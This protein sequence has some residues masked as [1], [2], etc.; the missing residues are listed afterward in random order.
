MKAQA[1]AAASAAA[2]QK[3]RRPPKVYISY[4]HD[5][6]EHK[7]R[8]LQLSNSLREDGIDCT[9]DRYELSPTEGW[10][11][12]SET[13]I[14]ESDF[15]LAA[16]TETYHRR[17]L[18]RELSDFDAGSRY[19]GQ[20]II[21]LL[22]TRKTPSEKPTFVPVIF[23]PADAEFI[24]GVLARYTRFN[25][26]SAEDYRRLVLLLTGGQEIERPLVAR[27]IVTETTQSAQAKSP[28]TTT[29]GAP[30]PEESSRAFQLNP[31]RFTQ[32]AWDVILVARRLGDSPR[33]PCSTGRLVAAVMMSGFR[34][35]GG[36][37]TGGWLLNQGNLP[38]EEIAGRLGKT[39]PIFEEFRRSFPAVVNARAPEAATMT[40]PLGRTLD[41]AERLTVESSPGETG[42]PIAVRHLLAAAV[43]R[44]N[45]DPEVEEFLGNFQLAPGEIRAK[46]IEALP[47]WGV[48]DDPEVWRNILD[49]PETT[50][51]ELGL[52]TY[53]A[54]SVA[55][56]DSIGITREVEAMA[57]L[58][59]AWSV[60][61]P[62]S[63]GLFG[64]WG[65][66]KSFFM[67]KMKERV[68][69]IASAARKSGS[70]QK[71][72]GY[73]KN[74]VQV[75]F[76]AWHYVEGNLWASLVEHIFSNLRLE[77]IGEEDLDS[78]QNIRDRLEKLLGNLREKTAEAVQKE[79]QAAISS[80]EAETKKQAAEKL[81]Q[82]LEGEA[83][84][85]RELARKAE[86]AGREAART[87]A[88]K[89]R[90]ADA[91][92]L[93]RE[94][95]AIKDVV[96]EVA[97]S[98][99]IRGQVQRDLEAVGITPERIKTGE[100]LR[101]AL[102]EASDAGIVLGEGIRMVANDKQRWR[103]VLWVVA[104]PIVMAILVWAGA[105]LTSQQDAAWV[106]SIIGAASA[107]ATVIAGVTGF[108]KRYAPRL[109]PFL[110][111]VAR[112]KEKRATLEQ[113]LQKAR[114]ERAKRAAE[115]DLEA[116]TKREEAAE[117]TRLAQKKIDQ[118][119]AARSAAKDK[120]VDADRAALLAQTAREEAEKMR[121]E[122][123]ALVPE[124]RIAAFIQDRAGAKDYRRHLGVP[125]LIRRDFEKLSAMFNTQRMQEDKGL[126]G[127]AAT[128]RNDLAIVNRIILYIDDLDRCPPEKVV[129][130]LRA[131][132]LLLAFPLFVVI[133]AVDARWMKRSLQDRFSLM[134]TPTL[135]GAN[136]KR[137]MS[138]EEK[139]A[140]GPMA[141]PDDYLEK[142]FQ[143]PFWIRPLNKTACQRLVNSLTKEDME[144]E[145]S[146]QENKDPAKDS[147]EKKNADAKEKTAPGDSGV[148]QP[149]PIGDAV[150]LKTE[151][152]AA[153][154]TGP[155]KPKE[156]KPDL[157]M[158]WSK[159][160]PKPRTLQLTKEERDYMVELALVI[161]RSPRSVKRFVNC[162]R[163]L[164]TALDKNDL[165]RVAR[166]GT[167]RTTMLLLGLVS[168]LPDL[169]PSLLADLRAAKKTMRPVAWAQQAA[170]RLDLGQQARWKEFLPAIQRL[171][172]VSKVDTI[173]P[174]LK[175]ADLVDR[176]SFSPVRSAPF[177][178]KD[179]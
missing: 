151:T 179:G 59:S 72:F 38:S 127:F 22:Q 148:T 94:S 99:E 93:E 141:T 173:S 107:A 123:E 149:A 50:P 138:K 116:Q 18:G 106:Q 132:H 71:E 166:D 119:E 96:E 27:K 31:Q 2:S 67:Q 76:N 79:E 7:S 74:I 129:E 158:E 10:R 91:V 32:Y 42:V 105:W 167:F 63:I 29:S 17:F 147:G 177:A 171:S 60:Q 145:S 152:A 39:H 54:D 55:G 101:E 4:S 153:G 165:E 142:I 102:K 104:A 143:V 43:A 6:S 170:K 84:E 137:A 168:G 86:E 175:A 57:S 41:L 95:I 139:L 125:A 135:D 178:A 83:A 3:S 154:E 128:G 82:K 155:K 20:L 56:P 115:L 78:E 21:H 124:R 28:A 80:Q 144:I 162:Y 37:Y 92:A 26:G 64:E 53:A 108:W 157:G 5:S 131:I 97:G 11:R 112:I 85:A 58:V 172:T 114:E 164:K 13:Q 23:V 44:S 126:D 160:E 34:D 174:L 52:P 140:L 40:A 130:V 47:D 133:V 100:G 176:F 24:P 88:D 16:C 122:A 111:A 62:L 14:R 169:A 66:G 163:L 103:L 1:K 161:G 68:R 121:R 89:Q 77:G 9:I 87:A 51:E 35:T 150:A 146:S 12:W 75:E 109:K 81:A 120:Q 156:N 134:L 110:D 70:G 136:G 69:Q 8:V 118:A 30:E 19:E 65:S 45:H 61:P 73:Y 49:P 36:R 48:S 98:A 113:D 90:E 15:V 159:V 33:E 25:V 117:K 46:M